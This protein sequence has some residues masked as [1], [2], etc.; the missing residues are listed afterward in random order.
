MLTVILLA[1]I[2]FITL[3]IVLIPF[4]LPSSP[5]IISNNILYVSLFTVNCSNI[6]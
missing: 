3:S 5:Y 6:S 1:F 2:A 4:S